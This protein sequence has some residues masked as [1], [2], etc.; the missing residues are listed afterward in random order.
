MEISSQDPLNQQ[1]LPHKLAAILY[2]DVEGYSRLT[3]VDEIGTHR[4]LSAYLDLFTETIKA[5]RGEVKHY[6][7]DAILADFTTVS[8]ALNCAVSFQRTM[9]DKNETPLCQTSCRL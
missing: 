2:A 1:A 3:G 7:G 9:K 8:D 5:Y 4:S 6:A